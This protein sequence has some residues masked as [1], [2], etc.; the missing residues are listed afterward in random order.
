MAGTAMMPMYNIKHTWPRKRIILAVCGLFPEFKM[1]TK[2]VRRR[3][4]K[5]ATTMGVG[6]LKKMAVRLADKSEMPITNAIAFTILMREI[7]ASS[8]IPDVPICINFFN[9]ERKSGADGAVLFLTVFI[10]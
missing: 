3:S 7:V 10:K 9:G 6:H 2:A 5:N 1:V 8:S 4:D